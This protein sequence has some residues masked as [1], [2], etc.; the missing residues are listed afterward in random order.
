MKPLPLDSSVTGNIDDSINLIAGALET[1]G[2]SILPAALPEGLV[3][4]LLQHFKSLEDSDFIRAGIGREQNFQH[5]PFVRSDAICWLESG[6]GPLAGYF[7][8]IETLRRGLNR[9]LFL[10]LFDYE[11]HYACYP[12]GAFY[13]KHLDAFRGSNSRVVSTVLY[14]NTDWQAADGGQLLL[15]KPGHQ[16]PL[17][18]IEPRFNTMVLFLSE[19][20]PHEVLV[21]SKPRYSLSGWFRVNN[22]IGDTVDPPQ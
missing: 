11:C 5:N 19:A 4:S 8:W 12:P 14:L 16:K 20:F 10:G 21:T 7:N 2:Y 15:Y 1:R 18:T 22:S 17:E 13:K 9:R 3:V 6:A